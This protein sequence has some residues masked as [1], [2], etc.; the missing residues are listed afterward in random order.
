MRYGT[1]HMRAWFDDF[2]ISVEISDQSL[3]TEFLN[4]HRFFLHVSYA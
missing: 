2:E 1:D 3:A 4:R